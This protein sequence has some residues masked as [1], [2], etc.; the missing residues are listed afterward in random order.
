MALYSLILLVGLQH[1]F[2][3]RN[4]YALVFDELAGT[5]TF[6][7]T[8]LLAGFVV[9]NVAEWRAKR[10]VQDNK[11]QYVRFPTDVILWSVRSTIQ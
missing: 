7:L 1:K 5:Y 6:L 9:K 10:K 2:Q 8:I 3:D 11:L 4:Q